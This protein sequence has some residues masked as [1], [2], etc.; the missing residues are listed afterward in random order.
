MERHQRRSR[1]PHSPCRDKSARGTGQCPRHQHRRGHRRRT[2]RGGLLDRP[3][4]GRR[5]RP[6]GR[7]IDG[8]G[9]ACP[10]AHLLPLRPHTTPCARAH[11]RDFAPNASRA[12]RIFHQ[13]ESVSRPALGVPT[14][15]A[16]ERRPRSA[17]SAPPHGRTCRR[18]GRSAS[19]PAAPSAPSVCRPRAQRNSGIS[20]YSL[21]GAA[22]SP[23]IDTR[24]G[25]GQIRPCPGPP[26]YGIRSGRAMVSAWRL[27]SRAWLGWVRARTPIRR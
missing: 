17:S 8:R 16:E 15:A 26:T 10:Q 7:N 6:S 25:C 14:R 20:F 27:L 12:P 4:A 21:L 24:G 19:G 9:S 23:R 22:S 13:P 5:C 1:L 2:A 18:F 11:G 3:I